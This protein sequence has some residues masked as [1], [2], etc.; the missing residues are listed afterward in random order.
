[1]SNFIPVEGNSDLVRDSR[2][3]QIINTNNTEYEQY[4]ARRKKRKLEKEKSLSVEQDLATLKNEMN[5][6]KSLLKELVNGN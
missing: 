4:L 3:N 6:I 1:M 2:T 5:E